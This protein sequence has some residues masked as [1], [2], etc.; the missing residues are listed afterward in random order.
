MFDKELLKGILPVIILKLLND[1]GKMYGYQMAQTVKNL[2]GD[3]ILIKEGSMY[4]ALHKFR[5]IGFVEIETENIGKRVRHYYYLTDSGKA[6]CRKKES[7][8]RAFIRIIQQII[9]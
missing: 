2:S 8:L 1:N 4:P 6:E 9:G 5:E 7:E 3:R